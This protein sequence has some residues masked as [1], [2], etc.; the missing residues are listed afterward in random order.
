M[1]PEQIEQALNAAFRAWGQKQ[2]P[3]VGVSLAGRP[4]TACP[5]S[6]N[7]PALAAGAFSQGV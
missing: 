6:L 1:T 3:L 7:S 4:S 5:F 2:S